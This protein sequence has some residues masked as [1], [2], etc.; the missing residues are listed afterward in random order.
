QMR[1]RQEAAR[2]AARPLGVAQS[3][4]GV[5]ALVL[6]VTLFGAAF[7]WIGVSAASML[8][9][10]S[11]E[12]PRVSFPDAALLARGWWAAGIVAALFVLAPVALYLALLED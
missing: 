5:A 3:V 1:A 4:A 7:S 8:G 2:S 11:F 6:A 10:I 9:A 12:I